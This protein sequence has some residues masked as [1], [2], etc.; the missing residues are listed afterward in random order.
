MQILDYLF[1]VF[2]NLIFCDTL[3]VKLYLRSF[4]YTYE[5]SMMMMRYF[6][7]TL[8]IIILLALMLPLFGCLRDVET[9]ASL[10]FTPITNFR[11]IP[12]IT[13]EEIAAIE[14][15]I[16]S[17]K[18]FS[19]AV[20]SGKEC[21]YTE[22]GVLQGFSVL[23]CGWLSDIFGITFQPVLAE[24][25][26][27]LTGLESHQYDFSADIP[28]QWRDDR[29][30]YMTGAI[31]E[32]GMRLFV[33]YGVN[34]SAYQRNDTP[35][36]YGYLDGR[37]IKEEIIA[38]IGE[39]NIAVPVPN[40]STANDMLQDGTLDIFIGEETAG[41]VITEYS[42]I[43]VISGLSYSAVSIATGNP[44]LA[45]LVSAIQK[46]I[47]ADGG[48]EL[49]QLVE[50]GRYLYLREKLMQEL[51]DEEKEYLAVH[52]NPAAIIPVGIEYDSYPLS[53]YNTQ[54]NEWQGIVVDLID[55]IEYLTGMH[56]GFANA[57]NADWPTIMVML[58]N[59]TIAMVTE[60][61]R[62]PNRESAFLWADVPSLTDNYA[63]LSLSEYPN[64]NVSQISHSRVGLITDAA[65]TEVFHTL[66]PQH[67]SIVYYKST[68]DAFDGLERGEVDILMMTRNL[69]L[70][71]TNYLEKTGI[72]ENLL[73]DR[74]YESY[75]GFNKNEAVLCS[76]VSKTMRLLDVEQI[77]N[78]WTRKVFDYRGKLARA[79]IP[80]LFG[81]AILMLCVLTLL[82]I[83]LVR[84]RQ[85]GR[86]LSATVEQRTDELRKR[87]AELE[88]QTQ[89]AQVASRAKS[90]FLSRMSHEI[91]TPL[92]AIIG[93]TE[94]AR[95][96]VANNPTKTS[97]SL[98][99][100][101]TAS[102][103]LMGI[104][105]DV[106]DMSKIES[107]KFKLAHEAFL[108]QTAMEDV[109][110]I[111]AQ[112]CN[113]KNICFVPRFDR[114]LNCN[115]LGD[116]LRL[117]QVLINLL[118]NAVKFTPENGE[119]GFTVNLAD[120]E[121]EKITVEYTVSDNGIGISGEQK[122]KLFKTFEQADDSI[123]IRFGGTGLG[124]AISQNLVNQMGGEITVSSD[125][126]HGSTFTFTLCM[127]K[128]AVTEAKC[129][130]EDCGITVFEGKR[131]LLAEDI[132]INK[133]ILKELLADTLI[134]IDD[135]GDG[136]QAVERFSASAADY[137]DL[138]FMDI[139]MPNMDGYEAT[140]NI[141]ALKRPDAAAIPILAMT[142]NAYREDIDNALKSGMNG[143][144]SKP[145]DINDVLSAL[146]QW[147]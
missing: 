23:V 138:I 100:I 18:Q 13:A 34:A 127:L 55:E 113:E 62:T 27:L 15:I 53:F 6:Q 7:K 120:D 42:S 118:G 2:I 36:R 35:L 63:L 135:V 66:Y 16:A 17:H 4:D 71:A 137:Y 48:Y 107:G 101:K 30:F 81:A 56:F 24:W 52:Q 82:V 68:L 54:E 115:V 43:E 86:N 5:E 33:G 67:P 132:E 142:A 76:I 70:N 29:R 49:S 111:I 128:A 88:I 109:S 102:N 72:K 37:N 147:L 69:L 94:I 44:E 144:L 25:D 112:R 140:R 11:E 41:T 114:S 117:N 73:F 59:H 106:L 85:M 28:T 1:A 146:R 134:E 60:L 95:R 121:D 45:P 51:T 40:L 123:A 96:S 119:I 57:R 129:T 91:R 39:K 99:E 19:Y 125:Y 92:N 130:E 145:I 84:N 26:S 58:E 79:Q 133:I 105:N 38:Y 75:F 124:L 97:S 9:K 110:K 108:L 12:D 116:R 89:T 103:H 77:T 83:L 10:E 21:F 136:Q 3:A 104:L 46:Y 131:I 74:R 31:A 98:E 14:S 47:Q 139:Q 126:G 90:E 22:K 80:Y 143:H 93:M 50:D 78:T 65:Y 8:Y 32:R 64:I 20:M 122:Q 141:R 87:T 61:I